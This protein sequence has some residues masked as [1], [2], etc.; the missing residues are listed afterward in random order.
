MTDLSDFKLIRLDALRMA[1]AIV[2]MVRELPDHFPVHKE[3]RQLVESL[4]RINTESELLH[5]CG[6]LR[7]LYHDLLRIDEP[8]EKHH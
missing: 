2:A 8:K 5:L 7:K 1:N 4:K 3:V 6:K